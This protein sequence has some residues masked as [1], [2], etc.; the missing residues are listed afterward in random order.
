MKFSDCSNLAK[1]RKLHERA[2]EGEPQGQQQPEEEENAV[3]VGNSID[4]QEGKF[5]RWPVASE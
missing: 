2:V 1:H 4:K 5:S 3:Q